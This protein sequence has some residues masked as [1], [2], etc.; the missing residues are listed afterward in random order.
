MSSLLLR[1]LLMAGVAVGVIVAALALLPYY[2]YFTSHV[3]TDDAYVDG[4]IV[5]VTPRVSGTVTN[6]YVA[7]NWTVKAGDLLITLDPSD[8]LVRVEQAQAQLSRARE[9]IDQLFSQLSG[10]EA[11]VN[12][13]EAQ[14]K[15]AELDYSRA[16]TLRD[17]GIMSRQSYDQAATALD[18]AKANRALAVQEVVRAHAALG[19]DTQ[20]HSRYERSV[21]QQADAAL[22]AARLDLSYTK[23]YAPVPGII[24][25]KSVHVGHRV[26]VGQPLMSIV[27]T[28]G[29]YITA[30][31]K[32]TQLTGVR[33]GQS[34][35]VEADI[36]PGYTYRGHVDSISM[37]TGA[38]FS[39]LPPEN[40]TGNWVKV[41]QRIPVKIVF[42][43]PLPA[44]KP[45]RLGLSV[46]VSID[47][48]DQRGP[49]LSSTQQLE[50]EDHGQA[51]RWNR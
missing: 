8:F 35:D 33:V 9:T 42:D 4:N 23:I 12:L 39:L 2:R 6:I 21:V 40:A 51:G 10:A 29:L 45:L 5:L 48:A 36:Y 15:Q 37:G 26:Q 7:D 22:E 31:F 18:V 14:L 32:E 34:A 19:G 43:S 44:E 1:R 11:G 38:A 41:V 49:L 16:R 28:N 20:D 13:A 30:N 50:H 3:S 17:S 25:H 47:V 46:D 27:G 24:T